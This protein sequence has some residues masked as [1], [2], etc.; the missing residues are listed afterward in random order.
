MPLFYLLCSTLT[1][2]SR[3]SIVRTAASQEARPIGAL[4][5]R[6]LEMA[7]RLEGERCFEV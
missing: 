2:A 5:G 4:Y 7:G 3:I 1:S 6:L